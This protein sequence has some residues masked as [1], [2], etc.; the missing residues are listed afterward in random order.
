MPN[1]CAAEIAVAAARMIA[2]DGADYATAKRRAAKQILGHT[3]VRKVRGDILPDNAQIEDEV[4]IY[5]ALFSGDSN[6]RG[7]CIC[8]KWRGT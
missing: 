1:C 8:A 2:Q 4:R 7:Y 3:K 6:R 5:H